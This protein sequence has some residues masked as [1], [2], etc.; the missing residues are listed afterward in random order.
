MKLD[1]LIVQCDGSFNPTTCD[2]A[3]F[4]FILVCSYGQNITVGYTMRLK[5]DHP[6]QTKDIILGSQQKLYQSEDTIRLIINFGFYSLV[7]IL[8]NISENSKSVKIICW[9]SYIP[10][11]TNEECA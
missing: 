3:G 1:D 8:T 4:G 7:N 9:S 5:L 2:Y 6:L 11:Y 10:R